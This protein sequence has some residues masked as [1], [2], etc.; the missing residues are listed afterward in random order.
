MMQNSWRIYLS[1]RGLGGFRPFLGWARKQVSEKNLPFRADKNGRQYIFFNDLLPYKGTGAGT[2]RHNNM[3]VNIYVLLTDGLIAFGEVKK[4]SRKIAKEN[5]EK[6]GK[7]YN[8][9]MCD[10]PHLGRVWIDNKEIISPYL[11]EVGLQEWL[12]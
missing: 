10:I 9:L 2:N 1:G 7:Y 3:N 8:S 4:L 12:D 6:L 5:Q 11:V